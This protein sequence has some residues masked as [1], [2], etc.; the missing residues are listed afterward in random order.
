MFSTAPKRRPK[1]NGSVT[2]PIRTFC[3]SAASLRGAPT[4]AK[5]SPATNCCWIVKTAFL[6]SAGNAWLKM[7]SQG[8]GGGGFLPRP[9]LKPSAPAAATTN[10]WVE[11]Y[12]DRYV[13]H[14]NSAIFSD[15]VRV[16]DSSD[17]KVQGKMNC[18][19]LTA[20]FTGTNELQRLVAETNVVIES[21]TNRFSASR[22]VYTGTN[23]IMELIGNPEWKAGTRQGKG[24]LILVNVPRNE[25]TV[26]TNATMRLPAGELGKTGIG[27]ASISAK[28][29][30]VIPGEYAVISCDE[31]LVGPETS[32]FRRHVHIDHPQMKWD[33]RLITITMPSAGGKVPRMVADKNVSFDLTDDKGQKVHGLGDR[34]VYV[35]Q[36]ST[37]A[38]NETMELTGNPAVVTAS[39]NIVG[40]NKVIEMNLTTHTVRAPGRYQIRGT[41]AS[42]SATNAVSSPTDVFKH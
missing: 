30:A 9:N 10:Q 32:Q 36:A 5:G 17:D 14:T 28:P 34:S 4:S 41:I 2:M 39:T 40:R 23:G 22:A 19:L 31:Y 12:S 25:M 29:S 27:G 33:S 7:P 8:S 42:T 13:I 37:T 21:E 18:A 1:D 3:I 24:D 35:Y 38:T 26:L 6:E 20:M 15:D 11:I 16:T